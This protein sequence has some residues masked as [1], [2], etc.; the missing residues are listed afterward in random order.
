MQVT[1]EDLNTVKKML[2][3]EIPED[4]VLRELD[5]AYKDLGKQAKIK[6]FR[7]GKAPRPVLER[8]FKKNVHADVSS[9]LI[10]ASFA[11]AI[12]E[13][14]IKFIGTPQIDPHEMNDK[15]PFRY[16]ATIEVNPEMA[17]ID[18]KG[19]NLKRTRYTI[20]DK[21][22]DDQ[23]KMLQKN[24]AR[25][26][27]IEESRP[28]KAG[29]FVLIDYAGFKDG[30]P[31]PEV[32]KTEN[33]S[34]KIGD[35][36][37][38]KDFDEQVAG[39]MPGDDKEVT[40]RFSEDY[41]NKKLAN[42]EIMYQVTLREIREEVL[43]EIDDEFAKDLGKYETLDELK[44]DIKTRMKNDYD[45]KSEHD[46]NQQIFDAL[47]EKKDFETPDTLVEYELEGIIAETERSFGFQNISLEAI[48]LNREALS[49]RY[50]ET[51]VKQVKRYLIAKK[52]IEQEN[53]DLSDEEIEDGFKEI[54]ENVNRPIDEIREHYKK[55]EDNFNV[56]KHSL[57][58]KKAIKLIMDHSH[59]VD[60]EPE[61][62]KPDEGETDA[63][64]ESEA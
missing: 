1:V 33:Y 6:G 16:D 37:F 18:Y 9:K 32:G 8:Y 25:Q 28:V 43:P 10:Q 21:E 41:V 36:L 35:G 17:D 53:V 52:L 13:N 48:G 22:V 2:H 50:R 61:V 39:M 20:G 30:T 63:A 26:Q 23:L 47:I 7:P 34:M 24:M 15:G 40:V 49:E 45:K 56:Y 57:L 29:D 55:N 42:L 44:A 11:E 64:K 58:E 3:I 46:L 38:S 19:L 51:A 12:T 31:F 62:K 14:E 4:E 5:K 60:V 54:S 59:I 27:T